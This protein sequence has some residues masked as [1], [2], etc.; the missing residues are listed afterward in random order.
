M[1]E[2]LLNAP[3][4]SDPLS[5]IEAVLLRI[6]L[7]SRDRVGGDALFDVVVRKA[8]EAG[9]GGATVLKGFL[10]Y[11]ANSVVHHAGLFHLSQDL[12]VIIEL[13]DEEA[14]I[15]AFLPALEGLL[16]GGGLITLETVQV[17]GYQPDTEA[18]R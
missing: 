2:T 3:G 15:K 12:P 9:I 1:N 11:G 14:K 16:S 5:G 6:F 10:G 8:R 18:A 4:K 13:I 7:G 17:L